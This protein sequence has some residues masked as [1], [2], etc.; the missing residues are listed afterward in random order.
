MPRIKNL[1]VIEFPLLWC[2]KSQHRQTLH[3]FLQAYNGFVLNLVSDYRA[4]DKNGWDLGMFCLYFTVQGIGSSGD[5]C[6]RD[7]DV[8]SRGYAVQQIDLNVRGTRII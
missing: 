1:P 5:C 2:H 3:C 7:K 8:R 6:A 4:R